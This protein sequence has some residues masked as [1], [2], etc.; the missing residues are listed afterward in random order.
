MI[1]LDPRTSYVGT[2][3]SPRLELGAVAVLLDDLVEDEPEDLVELD[4]LEERVELELD[5]LVVLVEE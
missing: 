2:D 1:S 5:D 3:R 4:E